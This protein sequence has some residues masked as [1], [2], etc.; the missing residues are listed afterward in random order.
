MLREVWL[1]RHFWLA[2][3]KLDLKDRYRR[4]VLGIA[5][6]LIKPAGMTLILT[7]VF[8]NVFHVPVE[9]FTIHAKQAEHPI[10][11]GDLFGTQIPFPAAELR[12]FLGIGKDGPGFLQGL[13]SLPLIVSLS[14]G[15]ILLA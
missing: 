7:L 9:A 2:L 8:T 10:R 4:S 15:E 6:S 1:L 11:P 13:F 3:A 14:G 5:W 12:I